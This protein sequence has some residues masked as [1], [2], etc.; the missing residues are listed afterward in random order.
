ME[1]EVGFG[2]GGGGGSGFIV[3]CLL[4]CFSGSPSLIAMNICSYY[5][6]VYM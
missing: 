6:L 4:F 3:V 2:G 5:C 1:E